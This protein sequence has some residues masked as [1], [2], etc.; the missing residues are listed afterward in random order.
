M[1]A[2]GRQGEFARRSGRVLT[3][4]G[5]AS[6][7]GHFRSFDCGAQIGNNLRGNG[8]HVKGAMRNFNDLPNVAVIASR[9]AILST[10]GSH[11]SRTTRKTVL[12][13]LSALHRA[14]IKRVRPSLSVWRTYPQLTALSMSW[15]ICRLGGMHGE[16]RR[17]HHGAGRRRRI[18]LNVHARKAATA[19]PYSKL[20]HT[21][22]RRISV[23]VRLEPC[24]LQLCQAIESEQKS[25]RVLCR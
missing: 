24:L 18:R 3:R 13:N 4:G 6:G 14:R 12:G 5:R 1:A 17:M 8:Q 22:R 15:P 10:T 11:M 21:G 2:S 16:Q 25:R 23:V 19:N 9:R 7:F 20:R